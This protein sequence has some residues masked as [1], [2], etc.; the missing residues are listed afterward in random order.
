MR[1]VQQKLGIDA[2]GYWGPATS[3]AIQSFLNDN[4]YNLDVDGYFGPASVQ[5]LQDSLNKGL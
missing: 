1:A 2:D 4:G 5:A 3:R